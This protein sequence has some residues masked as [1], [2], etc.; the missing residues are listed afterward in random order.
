MN[1]FLVWV[2]QKLLNLL[3]I[4]DTD[5]IDIKFLVKDFI[6]SQNIEGKVKDIIVC[7][8]L[9]AGEDA[10]DVTMKAYNL[11]KYHAENN[12]NIYVKY[13]MPKIYTINGS[14]NEKDETI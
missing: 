11:Y 1:S 2:V 13:Y 12:D 7:V 14:D 6:K 3:N 10:E 5:L 4:A 9:L 8:C